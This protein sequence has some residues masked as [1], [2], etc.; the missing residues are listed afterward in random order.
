[1]RVSRCFPRAVLINRYDIDLSMIKLIICITNVTCTIRPE[2]GTRDIGGSEGLDFRRS[3]K[4]YINSLI[5]IVIIVKPIG[6]RQGH[7]ELAS[8]MAA[9]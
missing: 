7:L 5:W 8:T 1:M 4:M 9:L 6:L 2:S 3:W